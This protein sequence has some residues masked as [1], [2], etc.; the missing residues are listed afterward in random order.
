MG[1]AR[2]DLHNVLLGIC[3]NVYYRSP[4]SV[5]MVYPAIRYQKKEPDVKYAN[6]KKYISVNCYEIIVI[7]TRA[8]DPINEKIADLEYCKWDRGYR[9]DN[10]EHDVYTVYF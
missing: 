1:R 5:S 2:L 10:L 4:E 6:N 9:Y 3:E 7:S 8:D